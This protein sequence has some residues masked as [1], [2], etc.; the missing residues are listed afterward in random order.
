MRTVLLFLVCTLFFAHQLPGQTLEWI[1]GFIKN[2]PAPKNEEGIAFGYIQVPEDHGRPDGKKFKLAFAVL[3]AKAADARPDPVLYLSGGPGIGALQNIAKWENHFLRRERDIILVDFRGIGY[4][5]PKFCPELNANLWLLFAGNYVTPEI[6]RAVK[7][8]W[9][10]ACFERLRALGWD[11]HQFRSA[12]VVQDLELLREQLGYEQ[13]NVLS[14]S[15]GTRTAQTYLRDAP[16]ALRAVIL[17]STFPMGDQ[18]YHPLRGYLQSLTA[19]FDACAGNAACRERFPDLQ[20]RFYTI[21]GSLKEQPIALKDPAYPGGMFH[22][23]L[24]DMHLLFFQFL[25]NSSNYPALPYLIEAMATGNTAVFN[26]MMT[27]AAGQNS[28]V[29]MATGVLVSKNDQYSPPPQPTISEKDPLKYALNYFDGE[30]E[31]LEGMDFLEFDSLE[32]LP[33]QSMVNTLILAGALDPATPAMYGASVHE[34]LEN[35]QFLHFPGIGHGVSRAGECIPQLLLQFLQSPERAL[36]TSCRDQIAAR[37][38]PFIGNLYENVKVGT[39]IRQAAI[40]K[41][42]Q[43]LLPIGLVVLCWIASLFQWWRERKATPISLKRYQLSQRVATTLGV[44]LIAGT[45]WLIYQTSSLSQL[46]VLL[47][48]VGG[49][50]Y[51][52]YL[53]YLFLL[54]LIL[55]LFYLIKSWKYQQSML[56]KAFSIIFISSLGAFGSILIVYDLFP[57]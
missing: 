44:V 47:G 40:E 56:T 14:V 33:V 46:L 5:E 41:R 21:T 19:F 52:Y 8:G 45:G 18:Q 30:Y 48:L 2:D 24:Q 54:T 42:V 55:S 7:A 13:W 34:R 39:L 51:F 17:D 38:I 29:S 25:K 6:E 12:A 35:S 32:S 57:K 49:A 23:N 1:D 36:E 15:Y 26:N 20:S 53:S 22:V 28:R 9:F 27:L 16:D 4:S 3:R 37:S 11:L 43:V 10:E 31:V 50:Q